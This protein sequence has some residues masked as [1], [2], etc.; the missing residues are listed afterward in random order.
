MARP[1]T[2]VAKA[3][4]TGAAAKNPG[5]HRDRADP[6]VAPLPDPPAHLDPSAQQA[7]EHFRSELPWLTASD[8]ALLEVGAIVRG[9]LLIGEVPGITALNMY[10]S[11]LSKLGAT[12]TDRSKVSVPNDESEETDEFF[13]D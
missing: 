3:K 13:G 7:W 6:S 4:V 5:R 9:R 8:A 12:P 10:Q 1:R 11:V 2:P